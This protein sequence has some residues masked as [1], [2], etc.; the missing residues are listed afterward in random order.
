MDKIQPV[1]GYVLLKV[2]EKKERKTASGIIVPGTVD[3]KKTG[4]TIAA[5]ASDA[6]K[7]L[8]VGDRVIFKEFSGTEIKLEGKEH[9]LMEADDILAK[10]VEVDKI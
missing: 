7:S 9:L 2:E 10:F 3:E 1:N 8:A 5:I 6:T 4:G